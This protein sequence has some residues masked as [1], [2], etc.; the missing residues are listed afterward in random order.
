MVV[1]VKQT[2]GDLTTLLNASPTLRTVVEQLG[3]GGSQSIGAT[4]S[5]LLLGSLFAI[6]P[7]LLM[8]FAVTQVNNWTADA[9]TGRL[10]LLL[11]T[12]R[13]RPHVL[14]ARFAAL[15]TAT[16]AIGV[17]TLAATAVAAAWAGVPLD[18]G[19]LVGATLGMIPLG[20]LMAAVGY[21][22]SGW[23]RSAADTGLLSFLLL[24]WFVISFVGPTIGWPEA[25]LRLS[26]LTYYG[27]PLLNGLQASDVLILLAATALAL[28]VGAARFARKDL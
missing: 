12:P 8:A 21:L 6:L 28:S 20:L 14:L 18:R 19:H 1:V 7:L 4:L 25:T 16:L 2:E 24:A 13:S 10:D 26:A 5:A 3:G 9:D 27:S 23:L 22:A 11:S 15:S 17:L